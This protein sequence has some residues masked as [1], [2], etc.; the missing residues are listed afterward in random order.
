MFYFFLALAV[1]YFLAHIGVARIFINLFCGLFS[2]L[3][4]VF[5]FGLGCLFVFFMGLFGGVGYFIAGVIVFLVIAFTRF[6]ICEFNSSSYD[7]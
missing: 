4:F 6:V 3:L 7:D 2:V 5:V 1:C